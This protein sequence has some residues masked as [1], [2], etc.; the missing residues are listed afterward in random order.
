M[1]IYDLKFNLIAINKNRQ[2][3]NHSVY[4]N[5][6]FLEVVFF[7][8]A[9]IYS[10]FP[11]NVMKAAMVNVGTLIENKFTTNKIGYS[12]TR[13]RFSF[14]RRQRIL[15]ARLFMISQ[16]IYPIVLPID[17]MLKKTDIHVWESSYGGQAIFL[18]KMLLWSIKEMKI[19]GKIAGKAKVSKIWQ[20]TTRFINLNFVLKSILNYQATSATP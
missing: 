1:L 11:S 5:S 17:I 12:S 8:Y 6:Q 14:F 15:F 19:Q 16:R 18:N 20:N 4:Q 3:H 10:R 13:S 7:F 9:T 2:I